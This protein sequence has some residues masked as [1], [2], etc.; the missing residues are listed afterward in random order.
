LRAQACRAIETEAG[1]ERSVP[2]RD[3]ADSASCDQRRPGR[4]VGD[5]AGLQ[6][7]KSEER[8]IEEI[9][10]RVSRLSEALDFLFGSSL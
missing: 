8:A 2:R 7:V 3:P 1:H 5:C 10:K 4:S 9:P 6:Y